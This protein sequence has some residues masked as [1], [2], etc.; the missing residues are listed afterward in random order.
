MRLPFSN[1]FGINNRPSN[2]R[3]GP[4][5]LSPTDDV[6]DVLKSALKTVPLPEQ[7]SSSPLARGHDEYG[8]VLQE[9][10]HD[11]ELRSRLHRP[12]EVGLG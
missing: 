12:I 1:Y 5:P 8:V 7:P 6:Q 11:R 10:G 3:I 2:G 9:D 4:S